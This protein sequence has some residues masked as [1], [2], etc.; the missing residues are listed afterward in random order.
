M[1]KYQ[2]FIKTELIECI[3]SNFKPDMSIFEI[4][5]FVKKFANL[6]KS[7]ALFCIGVPVKTIAFFD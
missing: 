4:Y 1:F 2:G 6:H 7:A 3:Y 5:N